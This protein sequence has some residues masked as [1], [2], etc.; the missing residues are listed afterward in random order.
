MNNQIDISKKGDLLSIKD[1][2]QEIVSISDSKWD[3]LFESFVSQFESLYF[4]GW[5]SYGPNDELSKLILY[6]SERVLQDNDKMHNRVLLKIRESNILLSRNSLSELWDHYSY[7]V[8][9]F[10]NEIFYDH[11]IRHIMDGT[12]LPEKLDYLGV[13]YFIIYNGIEEDV[14]WVKKSNE[15]EWS[16]IIDLEIEKSSKFQPIKRQQSKPF[17]KKW[18]N[19]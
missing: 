16:N 7:R 17:F 14:L 3:F 13:K 9:I 15:F 5:S 11:M 18:F 6:N 1:L 4:W 8:L 10:T 19:W 2:S 12:V